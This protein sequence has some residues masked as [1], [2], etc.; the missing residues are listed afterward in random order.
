MDLNALLIFHEVV[1]R[2]SFSQASKKLKMPLSTVSRKIAQLEDQAGGRL[3][4]RSTRQLR[5]TEFGRQ[6]AEHAAQAAGLNTALSTLLDDQS[7]VLSGKLRISVPPS[8]FSE[9]IG[10]IVSEFQ[11]AY[12]SVS[13]ELQVSNRYVE[14]IA[15]GIDAAIRVGPLADSS[16]KALR[17]LTYRHQLLASPTYLENAPNL[18]KPADLKSHRLVSFLH[19]GLRQWKL[20][21]GEARK[22]IRVEPE[23]SL[24]DYDGLAQMLVRGAGVGELPPIV[25]SEF[26][27]SGM[28]LPVLPKWKL[29]EVSVYFVYNG[30]G[31]VPRHLLVFKDFAKEYVDRQAWPADVQ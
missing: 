20:T 30:Q 26:L 23:L 6:V 13:I 8:I 27:S 29:P 15:G 22:T 7:A 11:A 21:S 25:R 1:E 12:P 3:L 2:G 18:E 28:L 5:V 17:L 4:E 9:F 19:D 16:L 10:P 24:N 31:L 14:P